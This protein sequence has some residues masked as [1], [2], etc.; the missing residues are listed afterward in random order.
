MHQNFSHD[1]IINEMI[2]MIRRTEIFLESMDSMK[3]NHK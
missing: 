3:I 2:S 1:E